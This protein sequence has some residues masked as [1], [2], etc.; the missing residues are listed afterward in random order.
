[1]KNLFTGPCQKRPAIKEGIPMLFAEIIGGMVLLVI[2]A[3]F[4]RN[5]PGLRRYI[6]ISRM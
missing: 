5:L 4:L 3:A 2:I 1:M 6:R